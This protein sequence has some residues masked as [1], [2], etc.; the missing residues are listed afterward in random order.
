MSSWM[1]KTDNVYRL[2]HRFKLV[3]VQKTR[4][5]FAFKIMS[6]CLFKIEGLMGYK[7]KTGLSNNRTKRQYWRFV[8]FQNKTVFVVMVLC[9]FKWCFI[10]WCLLNI[11]Y[12]QSW[13]DLVPM[14]SWWCI[15]VSLCGWRCCCLWNSL[16]H[17]GMSFVRLLL[18]AGYGVL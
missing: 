1:V 15:H 7:P 17:N 2:S 18:K 12:S 3:I 5:I 14:W 4:L 11:Y 9:L 13:I 10:C 16:R 8:R 6:L